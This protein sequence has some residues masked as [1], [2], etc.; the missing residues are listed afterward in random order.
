LPGRAASFFGFYISRTQENI[1][2]HQKVC[3]FSGALH[4]CQSHLDESRLSF[5]RTIKSYMYVSFAGEF[6]RSQI[7]SACQ[8]LHKICTLYILSNMRQ[9]KEKAEKSDSY[10]YQIW[11]LC[12]AMMSWVGCLLTDSGLPYTWKLREWE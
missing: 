9:K 10:S 1:Q 5:S 6:S 7:Y 4:R 11:Q 8:N 12:A 3:H 2:P